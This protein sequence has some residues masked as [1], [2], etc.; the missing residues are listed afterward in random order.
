MKKILFVCH[1][2]ICRSPMAEYIMKNLLAK[3][4]RKDVL[5]ES[6]GATED[7]V[8]SP[9]DP[10]TTR[11]L[12]KNNVPYVQRHARKMTKD[13]YQNYDYLICMDEENFMDMN[14]ITGGDPDRKEYKL[15]QFANKNS[16]VED[17]WYTNDF[18]TAYDEILMGCKA[19]LEKI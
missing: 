7:A 12:E 4:G 16:D 6:A 18:D 1:G 11:I 19:L 3:S 14:R 10:R 9:M 8:G 17:P 2:N 15:M 5:V 13:D